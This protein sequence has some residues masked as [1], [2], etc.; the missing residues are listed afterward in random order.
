VKLEGMMAEILAKI[1]PRLYEK[2]LVTERGKRV[3]YVKLQKALY[4]TLTASLLFWKDLCKYLGKEG[5][6]ANPYDS[7]VMNKMIDGKQ[8][9]V[10]WHVDDLKISHVDAAVTEAI[11]AGLNSRY[12]KDGPL[13][14]TRGKI[15]KY[16]STTIDYSTDG[17]VISRMDQYVEELLKDAPSDMVGEAT[18]PAAEHLFKVN[19]DAMPL[20]LA[21]SDI[22]HSITAKLLRFMG[23]PVRNF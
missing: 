1:D 6:T 11:L 8:C 4:G 21:A 5:F 10:L 12:G 7:C 3:M 14:V 17:K 18:T 13:T 9:T 15:H 22:F 23:I 19:E 16:L 20:D 2:I